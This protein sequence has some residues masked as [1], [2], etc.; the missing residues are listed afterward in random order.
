MNT[1]PPLQIDLVSDVVC[2]WCIIGYLQLRK[3]LDEHPT[4]FVVSLRW[5]AFELNP[6]LAEEGENLREHLVR[7]LGPTAGQGNAV[8]DRLS[9]LGTSLGF[10]FD[11]FDHMRVANTFRAH[12]L[13]HWAK[14]LEIDDAA[15]AGS[16][17]GKQTALKLALFAAHFSQ[18]QNIND[19]ATLLDCVG[20][21]G[22]P[23]A[24]AQQVLAD[25][26]FVGSV[27]A[28]QKLWQEREIHAVP[29][30]IFNERYSVLGA[31]DAANFT[32]VLDKLAG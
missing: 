20:Q 28:E 13:L 27:R 10:S 1:N 12:Q 25:G 15:D 31:Q 17:A 30:F 21:A 23:V 14:Q 7:K 9:A 24:E 4:P 16:M 2:P 26:R 11:F 5:Q 32:R 6:Q 29:A 18:R 3:A 19:Q 22:L 8:R